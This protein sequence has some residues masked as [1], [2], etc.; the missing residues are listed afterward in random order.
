MDKETFLGYEASQKL[1]VHSPVTQ[2]HKTPTWTQLV[3]KWK[4]LCLLFTT[5]C[6][7]P[8]L[9]Y[10][11]S[12]I[13]QLTEK[14]DQSRYFHSGISKQISIKDAVFFRCTSLECS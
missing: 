2:S 13:T 4:D 14:A 12:I 6:N 8:H 1:K 9:N 5:I 11:T 10:G 3:P 7:V